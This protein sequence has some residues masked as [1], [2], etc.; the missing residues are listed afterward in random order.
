M[1]RVAAQVGAE[2]WNANANHPG[3]SVAI[4]GPN[5]KWKPPDD[6]HVKLN[7]DGSVLNADKAAAGFVIRD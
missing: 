2:F 6:S 1:L 4:Q 5:I 3:P 7:F